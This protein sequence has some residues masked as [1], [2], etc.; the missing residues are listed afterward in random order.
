M[1]LA[2]FLLA[3][4]Y[5]L[6]NVYVLLTQDTIVISLTLQGLF[7]LT[8]FMAFFLTIMMRLSLGKA[9]FYNS[10]FLCIELVISLALLT[11]HD[12]LPF[13]WVGLLILLLIHAGS[14]L[15]IQFR[16]G[17]WSALLGKWNLLFVI[18]GLI[19][20]IIFKIRLPIYYDTISYLGISMMFLLVINWLERTRT[21]K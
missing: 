1:L 19:F 11:K 12:L 18:F 17:K 2:S 7:S 9:T 6:Y 4:L 5:A 14:L 3:F 16:D 13:L 8:L 21:S 20:S 15:F 10:L